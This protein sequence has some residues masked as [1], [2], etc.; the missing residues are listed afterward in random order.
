[1]QASFDPAQLNEI[2]RTGYDV[3][4]FELA[5]NERRALF[6]RHPYWLGGI[7]GAHT[8]Y[9]RMFITYQRVDDV[10][11]MDAYVARLRAIGRAIDQLRERVQLAAG[12]GIRMPRFEYTK[13]IASC[14]SLT[15][16]APFADAGVDSPL[17]ADAKAEMKKLLD[18]GKHR[19]GRL[20]KSKR[21]CAPCC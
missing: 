6:P 15:S 5:M 18:A 4:V 14:R 20:T 3:W 13:S 21:A 12:D 17:W 7:F 1:M 10:A 19:L 11:D 2:A 9:P 8:S 16:G